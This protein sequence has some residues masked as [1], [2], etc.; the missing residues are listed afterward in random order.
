MSSFFIPGVLPI[1][2][3][4]LCREN[5]A[6]HDGS[7]ANVRCTDEMLRISMASSEEER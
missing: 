6:T 1:V 2:L 5:E 7:A 3:D 4:Q